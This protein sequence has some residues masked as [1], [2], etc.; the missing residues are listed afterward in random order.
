MQKRHKTIDVETEKYTTNKTLQKISI[1]LVKKSCRVVLNKKYRLL[2]NDN[3]DN[4]SKEFNTLK[5]L[6]ESTKKY[7]L[8]IIKLLHV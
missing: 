6:G 5:P 3:H 4:I 2:L 8:D 7:I 1:Y